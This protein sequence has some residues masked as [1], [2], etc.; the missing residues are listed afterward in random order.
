MAGP[1]HHPSGQERRWQR[2]LRDHH[3]SRRG[4][5]AGR[6]GG[7]HSTFRGIWRAG[8]A[9]R[10]AGH[11]D[12]AGHG[13]WP[14]RPA[15]SRH[16]AGADLPATTKGTFL[17]ERWML[18]ECM[19]DETG[20]IFASAFPGGDRMADEYRRF[21]D[22]EEPA[23]ANRQ[24]WKTC[25]STARTQARHA[26]LAAGSAELPEEQERRP[27]S[28]TAVSSSAFWPWATASSPST[29]AHAAPTPRSTPPA[30]APPRAWPW[31]RTGFAA[32]AAGA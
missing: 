23:R 11:H 4:D 12:P 15:R 32:A 20:V 5:Q 31:P 24:R 2:Q 19:R 9:R 1:P 16:P 3:R 17:P 28:S 13:C 10:G 6:A 7:H 27:M 21:Y 18:P 8:Q 22:V 29:S 30:P 26:R 14:R 25:D